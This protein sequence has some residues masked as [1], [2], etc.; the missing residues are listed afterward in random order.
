MDAVEFGFGIV[1]YFDFDFDFDK[2]R[3][4]SNY[5]FNDLVFVRSHVDRCTIESVLG[6]E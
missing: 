1:G 6:L 2:Y 5:Q 4:V 3:F